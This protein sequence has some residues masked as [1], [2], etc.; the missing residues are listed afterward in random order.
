MTMLSLTNVFNVQVDSLLTQ[1][2]DVNKLTHFVK[3]TIQKMD[4]ALPVLLVT[5]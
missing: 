5:V 2:V 3:L 1:S 4:I